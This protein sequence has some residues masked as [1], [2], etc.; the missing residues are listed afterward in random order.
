[1]VFT[2]IINPRALIGKMDQV[3][4]TESCSAQEQK[5]IFC[6]VLLHGKNLPR[7]KAKMEE[8]NGMKAGLCKL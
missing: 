5:K 7:L 4:P 8:V 3:R 1:M 2:N 6:G